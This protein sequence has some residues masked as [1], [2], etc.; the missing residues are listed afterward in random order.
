MISL[1]APIFQGEWAAYGETLACSPR[2]PADAVRVADLI[3]DPALL[4]GLLRQHARHLRVHGTDLR[5][6]ASAWSLHYLNALL[7][8]VAAAASLLQHGFPMA[9]ARVW[10][11]FAEGAVP[12]CFHITDEGQPLH[13]A[14][15]A[16]RYAAL[17]QEHLAPLFLQLTRLTRI[18]PKILWGN[19]ARYL[20]PVL[21]QG[22]AASGQAPAVAQDLDHLLH[23][24][25]W[26]R[27]DNPMFTPPRR[28]VRLE[29]GAPA[30]IAL[31][32]QCCLYYLLPE[33]G[34]CAACPLAPEFRKTRA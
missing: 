11:T 24:P 15:T 21:E 34:Y 12:Q 25:H 4:A 26:G 17:L 28:A 7:P 29:A 30:S 8:P 3:A 31:H 1:L 32:R 10:L 5:P 20:E 23:Q 13:G 19:A 27:D 9:P 33:E 22:L 2:V 16:E 6:V 14:G 18:A